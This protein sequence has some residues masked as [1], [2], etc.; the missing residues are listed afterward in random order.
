MR[1]VLWAAITGLLLVG[2]LQL[3]HAATT[4]AEGPF[5][6][7]VGF[8]I[9]TGYRGV[10]T[11][12][13]DG[14]VEAVVNYGTSPETLDQTVPA[15]ANAP[16]EAGLAIANN[17]EIGRTYYFEVEDRLSGESSGVHSFRAANAWNA[18][19]E[20]TGSYTINMLVQLT[21][22][23]LPPEVAGDQALAEL[24]QGMSI[25][26]ERV[27]DATD[28]YVRIGK[29]LVTDTN[30]DYAVNVPFVWPT[31]L[32]VEPP[33]TPADCEDLDAN[34]ADVLVE[35]A[36]PADSHTWSGFAIE[37][38]CTSFY[39]GRM[40]WLRIPSFQWRSDLDFAA[41]STHELSHYAFN[42]PD[43]YTLPEAAPGDPDC[44]NVDW[45]GSLMHNTTR[46]DL[47][48]GR[49]FMSELDRSQEVTPCEMGGQPFTWQTMTAPGRYDRIPASAATTVE[50]VVDVK[51]RGNE[52]GGRLELL[53]LDREPGASSLSRFAPN[54]ADVEHPPP[55]GPEA[56]Q[57][58]DPLGDNSQL[59]A[60][61]DEPTGGPATDVDWVGFEASED[62]T[63]SVVT[64]VAALEDVPDPGS[65]GE[66][67][68]T[69]FHVDGVPY[70]ARVDRVF[71]L[72]ET[73]TVTT[74]DG[75]VDATGVVD[76]ET[77]TVRIDLPASMVPWRAGSLVDRISTITYMVVGAV[78]AGADEGEAACTYRVGQEDFP[79]NAAP[80]ARDDEASTGEDEPVVVDVLAN[81]SDSDGDALLVFSVR[82]ARHGAVAL[83]DDGRAVRYTPARGWSGR[84][85]F[86]Y[87]VYDGRGGA[88]TATVALEVAPAVD[89]P[90]AADDAAVT[91]VDAP[92]TIAPLRND[93]HEDGRAVVFD[94]IVDT[95]WGS[96]SVDG[97][98]IRY[99]PPAGFAGRDRVRYRIVD[100]AG[101]TDVGSITVRVLPRSCTATLTE[102]LP[103]GVA[104]EGWTTESENRAV[105]ETVE[106]QPWAPTPDP[107]A[108]SAPFSWF[109]DATPATTLNTYKDDRLVSPAVQVLPGATLTFSHRYSFE[110]DLAEGGGPLDG[111]VLE[112]STDGITWTDAGSRITEGQYTGTVFPEG[113]NPL[114]SRPA[115]T[116]TAPRMG[117]VSVTLGDLAGETVRLRWRLGLDGNYLSLTPVSA[118]WWVDDIQVTNLVGDCQLRTP[119]KAYDD[120]AGVDEDSAVLVPVLEN[121]VDTD[122][123]PLEIVSVTAPAH[124]AVAVTE[125]GIRY[126]PSPDHHGID[127]FAYTVSDGHGGTSTASVTVEVSPVNDAPTAVDDRASTVRGRSVTINVLANDTDVDGDAIRLVRVTKPRNGTATVLRG[128]KVRYTP[129]GRF[130]GT[131]RFLTVVQD[132][133]GARST[134]L[135]TVTV[136]KR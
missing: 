60:R 6:E 66:F 80:V 130:V 34:L 40:G 35:T 55:C 113:D 23:E 128:G 50:H 77:D 48:A 118:G 75:D 109:S 71:P 108:A 72:G 111:G 12:Q 41:T 13:A 103:D 26:A 124:G 98:R 112:L 81:D 120:T 53:T 86:A 104:G 93:G 99:A 88:A 33:P 29:V 68:V 83:A 117:R 18:W 7:V 22:E 64:K 19:D 91:L 57:L 129:R 15:I 45:D 122:G 9:K 3:A 43:L 102:S 1:R 89:G 25:F 62:R 17:L 49:W 136:K 2:G 46:F 52:D 74:P 132:S 107:L 67:F 37:K 76:P 114:A 10:F 126:E 27:Y 36:P 85:S 20:A 92:V 28:G 32:F 38:P 116:G 11:W 97:D 61:E 106:V 82:N 95:V 54:D 133:H 79:T 44:R 119:P 39:V 105:L 59:R 101:R 14:P 65:T 87:T 90:E 96:S 123:D 47:S 8:A 134:A 84:D 16:D 100:D 21:T 125:G 31:E 24:S 63:V 127:G 131:D 135:V 51:S 4:T 94:G 5:S 30:L 78:G 110:Q 115:W 70:S 69:S 121:D 58:D 73:Y 42:A 56:P